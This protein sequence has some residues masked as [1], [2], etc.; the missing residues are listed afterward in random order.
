MVVISEN[1][2]K[3]TKKELIKIVTDYKDKR[4][5]DKKIVKAYSLGYSQQMIAEV[6]GISQQAVAKI[7]KREREKL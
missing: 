7:V 3:K 5:R 6:I 1:E 2:P 4:E